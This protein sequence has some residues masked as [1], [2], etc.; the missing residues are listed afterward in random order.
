LEVLQLYSNK[1]FIKD[2][3][4]ISSLRKLELRIGPNSNVL[5]PNDLRHLRNLQLLKEVEFLVTNRKS[6][7]SESDLMKFK[8]TLPNVEFSIS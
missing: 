5:D 6:P 8:K 1:N 2:I 4:K 7:Y 3:S